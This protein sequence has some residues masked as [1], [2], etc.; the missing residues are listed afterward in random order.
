MKKIFTLMVSM[1]IVLAMATAGGFDSGII[2]MERIL[3]QSVVSVALICV[4]GM[5]QGRSAEA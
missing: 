5:M 4:G 3:I 1:G 2:S